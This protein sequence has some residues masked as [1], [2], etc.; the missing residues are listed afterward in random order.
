LEY[1]SIQPAGSHTLGVYTYGQNIS[2]WLFPSQ[3]SI[4]AAGIDWPTS[5]TR[6]ASSKSVIELVLPDKLD[7]GKLVA[8]TLA[9]PNT[10]MSSLFATVAFVSLREQMTATAGHHH[11]HHESPQATPLLR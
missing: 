10:N 5:T 7:I 9:G 2:F 4:A 8:Y 1:S 11:T 6:F 3:A